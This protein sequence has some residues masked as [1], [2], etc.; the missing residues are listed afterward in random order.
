MSVRSMD[1]EEDEKLLMYCG[2]ITTALGYWCIDKHD[3]SGYLFSYLGSAMMF[4]PTAIRISENNNY[5]TGTKKKKML[6]NTLGI[7]L[8]F[9]LGIGFC[10]APEPDDPLG[11]GLIGGAAVITVVYLSSLI[12]D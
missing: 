8:A 6:L 9:T 1:K 7:P 12:K 2:I 3:G 11:G 5:T 10:A 4:V